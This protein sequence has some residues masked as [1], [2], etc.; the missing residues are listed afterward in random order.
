MD[1]HTFAHHFQ[2]TKLQFEYLAMK[3]Q[4][5][6][7]G[8]NSS[9]KVY[10]QSLQQRRCWCPCGTWLTKTASMRCLRLMCHSPQS[11]SA[12]HHVRN[13]IILYILAKYLWESCICH[14]CG[15]SGVIGVIVG[16]HIRVQRPPTRRG[17]YINHKSFYTVLLQGIVDVRKRFIEIFAGPPGKVHDARMLRAS[18]FHCAWQEKMAD[19]S[20]LG[21]GPHIGLA[22]PFI[23]TPKHENG[24]LTEADELQ[25]SKIRISHVRVVTDEP[26]E[27][28]KCKWE[29]LWDL[30]NTWIDAVVMIITAACFPHMCIGLS[31]ICQEHPNGCPRQAENE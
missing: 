20:L 13:R 28:F 21:D 29:H 14:L 9:V 16:C 1:D 7:N 11:T 26:L 5:N 17:D 8:K 30:Q 25:N 31:E 4:D 22:F 6:V 15:L 2:V 27:A 12:Q 10:H 19:N 24:S 3:L 18:D 23:V